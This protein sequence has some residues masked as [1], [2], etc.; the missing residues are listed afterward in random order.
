[1]GRPGIPMPSHELLLMTPS[2]LAA[3]RATPPVLP[4]TGS[5]AGERVRVMVC[6]T[7]VSGYMGACWRA[8]ARRSEVDLCIIAF[9]A[10]AGT[11]D[12][13]VV[14]GG[15]CIV[16]DSEQRF[17]SRWIEAAVLDYEPDVVV[18]PGWAHGAYVRLASR[19]RLADAG[20]VMAMDTPRR[21]DWRQRLARL[22]IGRYLDRMDRVVVAGERSWQYARY[23]KVPE[24]KIRRGL[25]GVDF[26]S[27]SPLYDRRRNGP[28]GWPRRFLFMGRYA[29]DK[30]VDVLAEAYREYRRRVDDPW[31]LST[32]GCGETAGTLAESVGVEDRGF[33]QP[34]DQADALAGHGVFV[35]ASRFDPWPLVIAEACAAGLPVLCTDACGSS[36]ELVRPHYNGILAATGDVGDL[37]AG[38]VRMHGN[39]NQLPEWGRR[40]RELAAAYSAE[41]WAQRWTEMVLELAG[42]SERS[43]SRLVH[44]AS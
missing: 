30:G 5:P 8:W 4:A 31:P 24:R 34:A 12:D 41:I 23:L 43:T 37:A 38:L 39:Y 16:L 26:A 3:C 35:L 36:V 18:L 17:D 13:Q 25:Y 27:L 42:R 10:P 22:K 44:P 9:S 28:D 20:F 1:M 6:W 2:T 14:G 32:C 7:E 15:P 19:P 21:F 29:A 40:S 33:L 11:F